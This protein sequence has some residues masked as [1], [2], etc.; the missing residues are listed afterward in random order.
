MGQKVNPISFRLG[1]LKDWRSKWFAPKRNYRHLLKRDIELRSFLRK[2]LKNAAVS[3]IDIERS[4]RVVS[5][6]IYSS[7]PGI[8]IGRGGSGI[9]ELK[10][11]IFTIIQENIKIDI[12]IKEI[13]RPETD[14]AIVGFLIAEQ[15]EKRIPFRRVIKQSLD[16]IQQNKEIQGARIMVAG[17]LDGSEMSRREWVSFGK[18]PLHT[19]RADIDFSQTLAHTTYGVIGIKVWLYKG[20]IFEEK[21][22]KE[23]VKNDKE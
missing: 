17:R 16:R 19:I 7:R 13:R 22:A 12:N 2:R 3:R 10:K 20:E 21:K 6:I 1:V 8:I 15:I 5:I 18:I 9:E 14:A 11:E 4:P 23:E